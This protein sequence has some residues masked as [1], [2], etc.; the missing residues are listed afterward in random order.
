MSA[1][2]QA[3][4]E[5]LEACGQTLENEVC[6]GAAYRR[7]TDEERAVFAKEYRRLIDQLKAQTCV[8]F[9]REN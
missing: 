3:T 9:S 6:T 5:D 8:I 2:V 1:A 7:L 4:L